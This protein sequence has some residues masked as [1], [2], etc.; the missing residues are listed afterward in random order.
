[1]LLSFHLFPGGFTPIYALNHVTLMTLTRPCDL[2]QKGPFVHGDVSLLGWHEK[3][4]ISSLWISTSE[5]TTWMT[6]AQKQIYQHVTLDTQNFVSG[7]SNC[8]K[9]YI[10]QKTITLGP[11]PN[12]YYFEQMLSS[13]FFTSDVN[14]L[15]NTAWDLW[16]QWVL[17][18]LSLQLIRA[19]SQA[20]WTRHQTRVSARTELTC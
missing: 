10:R 8:W 7:N 11:I 2:K 1:M 3:N 17:L 6:V 5:H 13:Y 18:C 15:I 4:N 14:D 12:T 16:M 9:Q 19:D 20:V